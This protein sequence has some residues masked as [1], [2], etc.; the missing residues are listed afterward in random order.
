MNRVRTAY[1]LDGLITLDNIKQIAIFSD[2]D[3]AVLFRAHH[4]AWEVHIHLVLPRSPQ[5]P[6]ASTSRISAY[7]TDGETRYKQAI[8]T[9]ARLGLSDCLPPQPTPCSP[10]YQVVTEAILNNNSDICSP[11]PSP[12]RQKGVCVKH[13]EHGT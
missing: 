9:M 12:A 5:T 10:Q 4:P 7:L 1:Q 11:L 13:S 6:P 3:S 2:F 8:F